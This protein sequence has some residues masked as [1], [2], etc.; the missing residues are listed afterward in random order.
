MS[1]HYAYIFVRQDISQE[2]Q[3]IQFG[4]VACVLGRNLPDDICPHSLNFVG[5]GVPNESKLWESLA[6]MA[7]NGVEYVAFKEPDMGDELTAVAS[8]P[9]AGMKRDAFKKFDTLRFSSN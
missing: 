1:D 7:L 3:L 9:I 6:H 8:L 2:Q 4:H 5:I